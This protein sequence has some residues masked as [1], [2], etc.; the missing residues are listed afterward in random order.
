[1]DKNK[2]IITVLMILTI[3]FTITGGTLAYWAWRTTDAQKTNIT[4]TITSDFS[5][6]ADGGGNI[7]SGSVK[8]VPTVVSSTTT[9]NYI[10]REVKVNPTLNT[11]DK[12][13]HMDLWLDIITL[14]SGLSNSVNFRYAFTTSST[15]EGVVSSGNFYGKV[16]NDKVI[17]LRGKDYTST[18]TETY[19]LW[20]WLD[21]A[22]TDS[23]TMNQNFS[24]KLGGECTDAVS[25][26]LYTANIYD[27][28]IVDN[29]AVYIGQK[30]S[31]N[32]ATYNTPDEAMNALKTAGG[33]TKN[34]P[35]FLKHTIADGS[36]WYA[37]NSVQGL[38][39]EEPIPI[40]PYPACK[41]ETS[42]ECNSKISN[43]YVCKEKTFTQGVLESYVGFVVTSEM[44]TANPGM[45][46]GTYYLKG[47]DD[48]KAFLDNAKII[49]DAFGGVG[50]YLDGT[51]G[52][53]PYTTTPSSYFDCHVSGLSA[54]A[55]SYGLVEVIVNS[56]SYCSVIAEGYS[57][58]LLNTSSDK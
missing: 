25:R 33:G 26:E 18:T 24:M 35:F 52:G 12:T 34:Y 8:L 9:A 30:L 43:S 51:S 31:N 20:I 7:T 37:T 4:F 29:N 36:L 48:G 1:M 32:I 58:C 50:C 56:N 44:A 2:R 42:S 27:G 3:V 53:N 15:S 41:Y 6:S 10:K 23:A 45:V 46:A 16:A 38:S 13:I 14:D 5:C 39:I 17:L 11:V 21:A 54:N 55:Y 28:G 19:Y 40:S 22:E 47:G 49:Y 57:A